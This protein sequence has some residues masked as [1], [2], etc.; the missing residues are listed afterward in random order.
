MLYITKILSIY[1]YKY[2]QKTTNLATTV[3]HYTDPV[4]STLLLPHPT[5]LY[6]D[7]CV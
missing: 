3:N 4:K 5:L 1:S 7:S 6:H 2:L